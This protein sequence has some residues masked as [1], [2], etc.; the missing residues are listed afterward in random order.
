MYLYDHNYFLQ[1]RQDGSVTIMVKKH[2]HDVKNMNWTD[3]EGGR[4]GTEREID[5]QTH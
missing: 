3:K 4:E 5:R 2:D 1:H